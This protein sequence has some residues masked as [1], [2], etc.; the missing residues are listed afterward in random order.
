MTETEDAV[1]EYYKWQREIAMETEQVFEEWLKPITEKG[2]VNSVTLRQAFNAGFWQGKLVAAKERVAEL[3][4]SAPK[5]IVDEEGNV[6]TECYCDP[7][8][9]ENCDCRGKRCNY[10]L[11]NQQ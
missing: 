2:Y 11:A 4:A 5:T 1:G 6:V 7:C 9:D 10:C 3:Q 8:G